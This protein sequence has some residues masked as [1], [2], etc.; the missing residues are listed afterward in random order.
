MIATLNS[1]VAVLTAENQAL[2]AEIAE[3]R[4]ATA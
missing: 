4:G 2:Q 1:R 3:L